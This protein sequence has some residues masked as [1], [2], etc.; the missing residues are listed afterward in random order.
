MTVRYTNGGSITGAA[1]ALFS[2]PGLTPLSAAVASGPTTLPCV[3]GLLSFRE[4]PAALDALNALGE[5]PDLLIC[6]GQGY[7]HP[8]RSGL[9]C[10]MGVITHLPTI[11]IA[12]TLL[13]GKFNE[14]GNH[15]R[16]FSALKDGG[17]TIGAALRTRPNVKPVFVSVGHGI[18]PGSDIRCVLRCTTRFRMPE[19]LRQASHLASNCPAACRRSRRAGFHGPANRPR[20]PVAQSGRICSMY[21]GTSSISSLRT[22][23]STT[24][25][26]SSPWKCSRQPAR[27]RVSSGRGTMSR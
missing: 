24:N 7:A 4:M 20:A 21:F 16:D 27:P 12:R 15:I 22:S 14:V 18:S 8:R 5:A 25:G 26:R 11:G 10:H 6:S 17:E 23:A 9:A 1:V 3:P 19:P 2:L 13:S